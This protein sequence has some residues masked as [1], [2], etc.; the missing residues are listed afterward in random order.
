MCAFFPLLTAQVNAQGASE[1]TLN[2]TGSV[3]GEYGLEGDKNI[4]LTIE[5]NSRTVTTEKN[6]LT[7]F[8]NKVGNY[9]ITIKSKNGGLTSRN[10]AVSYN[11]VLSQGGGR[12]GSF[13][14]NTLRPCRF[15]GNQKM[16]EC[17]ALK[18]FTK[19]QGEIQPAVKGAIAAKIT[20][21]LDASNAVELKQAYTDTLILSMAEF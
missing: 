18:I 17:H 10:N 11:V 15:T 12:W 2:L 16:E 21:N 20:V 6:A 1:A 3:T 8:S 14:A 13:Y 7:F 19:L 9:T 5:A 4:D